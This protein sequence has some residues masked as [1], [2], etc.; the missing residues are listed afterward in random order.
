MAPI[1]TIAIIGAGNGGCAAAVDL[2]LRGFDVRLYGRSPSTLAPLQA[3]QGIEYEGIFG[4]GMARIGVI[5]NDVAEAMRGAHAVVAMA[6]AH[7]HEDIATLIAPH[8]SPEQV[9]LAAPGQ[10]LTLI[11][12]ALRRQGHARPVTCVTSTLPYICRKTGEGHVRVSRAAARLR[13][14]AFPATRTAELAERL[15]PLFPALYPVPSVLDTLFPYTNAIHHPPALLCNIGRVEATGGDYCHYYEGITPSVGTLIDR[16]DDERVAVA[17]AFGCTIDRLPEHFFQMGYTDEAGRAGGTAYST[18]HHSE[19]NRWI[20]AP[21]TIDHRFFN[22]D[23]P[24]GLVPFA[25]LGRAAR[26]PTPVTDAVILLA[27][28]VTAKPYRDSGLNLT[29][30]GIAGLDCTAVRR[31]VEEGYA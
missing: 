23:I 15:R 24:F 27:S 31:L 13:F 5:T 1:E 19:P 17:Q 22:E 7:A 20:K 25:E 28:T 26:V 11:P 16:L 21:A 8:L 12:Q 9:F 3:R 18:F 30:L 4:D 6:P 2:T 10:T 14:A 29:R